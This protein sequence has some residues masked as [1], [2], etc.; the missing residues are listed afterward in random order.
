[1]HR[2]RTRENSDSSLS[3]LGGGGM[4]VIASKVIKDGGLNGQERRS[5]LREDANSV[6]SS[7]GGRNEGKC[8]DGE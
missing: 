5:A 6:Q 2:N 1:M 8:F 3:F 7:S 4:N